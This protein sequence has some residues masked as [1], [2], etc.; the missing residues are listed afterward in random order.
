ML[1]GGCDADDGALLFRRG[2]VILHTV[3]PVGKIQPNQTN[4]F[5]FHVSA[6]VPY[7]TTSQIKSLSVDQIKSTAG[8]HEQP[9]TVNE[10]EL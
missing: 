3:V 1:P 9:G 5:P 10:P 2:H 7:S 4:L 8:N 6:L